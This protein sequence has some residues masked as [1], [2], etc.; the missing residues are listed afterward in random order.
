MKTHVAMFAVFLS[1][2][3]SV[4]SPENLVTEFQSPSIHDKV[5][6]VPPQEFDDD[7]VMQRLLN[8]AREKQTSELARL[9]IS[10]DRITALSSITT[11]LVND[12][13]VLFTDPATQMNK[14]I[15]LGQAIIRR[16]NSLVRI[17]R[18]GQVEKRLAFGKDPTVNI[19]NGGD[20]LGFGG[21]VVGK[22]GSMKSREYDRITVFLKA[23]KLPTLEVVQTLQQNFQRAHPDLRVKLVVR[24]D[25][26][27]NEWGG[28]DYDRFELSQQS[29]SRESYLR[30]EFLECPIEGKCRKGTLLEVEEKKIQARDSLL[31]RK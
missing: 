9:T 7:T 19:T 5:V 12:A 27:F 14:P 30:S 24:T 10:N 2:C 8:F 28:P 15:L 6:L 22:F 26:F 20:A 29:F 4:R 18:G 16:N 3:D 17:R 11:P 21:F 13:G 25:S 31:E 1:G 23:K